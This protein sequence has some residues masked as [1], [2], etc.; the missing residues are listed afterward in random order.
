MP[1]LAREVVLMLGLSPCTCNLTVS[2]SLSSPFTPPSFGR[3]ACILYVYLDIDGFLLFS[4]FSLLL[5]FPPACSVRLPAWS[6]MLM[7]NGTC[8][9]SCVCFA[10][11]RSYRIGI[12]SF[13]YVCWLYALFSPLH[14]DVK[15]VGYVL[16]RPPF[17]HSSLNVVWL[18]EGFAEL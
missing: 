12:V 1:F 18:T 11:V 13:S 10:S 9:L 17:L 3:S 8:P 14:V 6:S 4:S 15:D 2:L 16:V 7:W 5:G